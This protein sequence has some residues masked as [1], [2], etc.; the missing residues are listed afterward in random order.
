MDA[1]P[2]LRHRHRRILL[3]VLALLLLAGTVA[4]VAPRGGPGPRH[5]EAALGDPLRHRT[6]GAGA[7]SVVADAASDVR[8]DG[9]PSVDAADLEVGSGETP[10][11]DMPEIPDE[12]DEDPGPW[13]PPN[14]GIDD[15]A[16][17]PIVLDLVAPVDPEVNPDLGG[18][19]QSLSG[20]PVQCDGQCIERATVQPGGTS[21]TI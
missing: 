15:F 2:T 6:G 9:A 4:L 19:P 3:A 21:G 5:D 1:T 13:F 18:G 14:H 20:G 16:T 12:D 7:A 10:E 11:D 17:P 8:G